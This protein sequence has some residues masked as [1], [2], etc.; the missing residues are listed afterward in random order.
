[1]TV[2]TATATRKPGRRARLT[3]KRIDPWSTLKFSFIYG[4]VGL[5]VLVVAVTVLYGIVDAMGVL[6]SLRSFFSTV[7]SGQGSDD[8]TQWFGF[9][10]VML[11]TIIVGVVNVVLFTALATLTA[12]IYNICTDITGGVEVTL[13]ERG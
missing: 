4:L 6:D 5:I 8:I 12:F 10:R 7:Q 9:G 11:A 3:V 1:M 2:G 13:A